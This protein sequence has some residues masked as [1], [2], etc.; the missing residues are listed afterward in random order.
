MK[1]I[2]KFMILA[3]GAICALSSCN[4]E[5]GFLDAK[6]A[7][8]FDT[9]NVFSNYTLAEYNIFSIWNTFGETNGYRGRFLPW[10]GLNSD[11]EWYNTFKPKDAKYT[12]AAYDCAT[13]NGQLNLANGP[14]AM[15]Y[16]GIEYCNLC[17]DGLSRYGSIDS[18]A[19]MAYLYAE[20]LTLRA[21]IYYDLTKTWGDVPARF[22]PVTSEDIYLP[23]SSR[24]VIFKQILADLETAIPLLPW[25]GASE[26]TKSSYRVSKAFAEGLYARIALAASGYALRP[27]DGRE[28][29]GDPGTVRKTNDPDLQQDILYPKALGYLKDVIANSG[30]RL[31]DFETYWRN[32]NNWQNV[33]AGNE[34]IFCLPYGDNRGRWNFT[35]A[36][37]SEGATIL[38]TAITRGGDC[39]PVPT[40]YF[41]YDE[42]DVRRDITCAN[43]KWAKES[44]EAVPAGIHKWYFGKYRF[45]WMTA[46][47][48]GGGND[49][50]I[51]PVVMRYSDIL[52]MAAE[53]EFALNGLTADA[54][55]W[56]LQVRSRAF[57]G[58][59]DK[60][61]AYVNSLTADTFFDAI[62][63][64][65]ALEFCGEMLRKNDLI[66]WNLLKTKMDE[67]IG[68]MFALRGLTADPVSGKDY[69]YL[70]G[71]V[72]YK[73]N[74]D[75]LKVDFY[76]FN[77]GETGN[78]GGEWEKSAGYITKYKDVDGET[79]ESTSVKSENFHTNK[80]RGLYY[81]DPDTRQFWPIF[82]DSITNSQNMLKNDYGY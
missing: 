80:I 28:G 2:F 36:I 38:G 60:A 20:A 65:R 46:H 48:Y 77:P 33:T 78:P 41:D 68:K 26:A 24:D 44:N 4:K 64:E 54:K 81:N 18:K 15:M 5:E 79:M 37:E 8:A 25:P 31:E 52:L 82:D 29:T 3:A 13:N 10:S 76:G 47:P 17:I 21:M 32:F 30:C 74:E 55:D 9:Q 40:M 59:E 70:S 16:R 66:R 19:D 75:A 62:V 67:T 63:D 39:G 23:R 14:Y 22:T 71:D 45:E 7:S 72:Y 73:Y 12:I 50:G 58:N 43:Y 34:T 51:K 61:E 27:D 6:S 35:F 42:G 11:I 57:K 69:S 49:D 56:F 1:N 53:I